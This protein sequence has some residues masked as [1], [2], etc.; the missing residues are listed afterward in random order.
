MGVGAVKMDSQF[1]WISFVDR[2]ANGDIT[3]YDLIYE[4][5]YETCM[6]K[7]LYEHHKDKY[8]KE[9]NRRQ[10]LQNRNR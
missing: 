4:M 3:K 9:I 7:M 2:L 5:N 6:F 8:H 1:N 10:Q